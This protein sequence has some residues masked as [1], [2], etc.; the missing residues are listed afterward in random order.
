MLENKITVIPFGINNA[1]PNTDLI[2][3]KAREKLNMDEKNRII[4]FFGNIAP[5]K[6]LEFLVDAFHQVLAKDEH[7]RLLV[8]G[9]VKDCEWYWQ[10]IN[11]MIDGD[12]A[13][14]RVRLKIKYIPDSETEVYFKAADLLVLPYR[15]IYQSGVLYLGYSFG[16]PTIATD[17]G[18]LKEEIIV[19][20]TGF[21]CRP[22]DSDDLARTIEKY[23]ESDLYKDLNNRRTKIQKF[24]QKRNSW[25]VV[26]HIT[27]NVY[28]NCSLSIGREE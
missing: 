14:G 7:I 28:E 2:P 20:E 25:E 6:G 22:E 26:A 15:N 12:V 4:L 9:R 13:A 17:V 24:A 18:A 11:K 10:G 3:E 19:E 16:L 8:A 23:F 27:K 5:Y 1:I 21:V